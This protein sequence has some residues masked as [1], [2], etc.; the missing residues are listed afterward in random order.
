MRSFFPPRGHVRLGIGRAGNVIGGG[1][2][3][4]NR[5][6]PDCIRSWLNQSPAEI[7]PPRS[8]RPWQHVLEPLSGYIAL[9]RQLADDASLHGEAF[10]FGPLPSEGMTVA[11]VVNRLVRSFPDST[12]SSGEPSNTLHEAGLLQLNC[13]KA[14][15]RLGWQPRLDFASTVDWTADWYRRVLVASERAEDV[16]RSQIANFFELA[17]DASR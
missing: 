8:T 7:R 9:A 3:A 17:G 4:S 13:D 16:T 12:W 5:V 1:D 10:N 14:R 6:V 2:W 11:D 15:L